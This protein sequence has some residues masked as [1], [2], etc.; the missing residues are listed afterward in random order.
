MVSKAVES[1]DY[2]LKL[3]AANAEL[4]AAQKYAV[5]IEVLKEISQQKE[6]FKIVKL[7]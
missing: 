7:T 3:D 2:E 5:A 6:P 1:K 4:K